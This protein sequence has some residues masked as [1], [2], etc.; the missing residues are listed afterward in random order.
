M[1]KGD[2]QPGLHTGLNLDVVVVAGNSKL[3]RIKTTLRFDYLKGKTHTL[4]A[5]SFQQG[6]QGSSDT[7]FINKGFVHLRRTRSLGGGLYFEGFVQKEFN[8]FI[9]L[10][11]RSLAGGGLRI[12]WLEAG[13][14]EDGNP[15]LRL[16]TGLGFMWEQERL[17][18]CEAPRAELVRSTNYVVLRWEPDA[19]R[20]F[21][22]TTYFQVDVERSRDHRVLMDG[23]LAFALTGK[24][25][26]VI[27][28]N[29]RYDHE[30]PEGVKNYDIEL[31]NG[32]SF[33]F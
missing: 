28:L 17:K 8:D 32:L 13:T 33:V 4:L 1:R 12:R 14:D 23:G 16:H 21:Q 29:A 27:R 25:S 26:L 15:A 11:D 19:R 24:L 9:R 5:G 30:P 3:L 6:R 18:D 31:T 22:V 20:L 2:L 7:L 10:K